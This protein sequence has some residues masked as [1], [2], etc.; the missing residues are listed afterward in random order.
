MLRKDVTMLLRKDGSVWKA[1]FIH[2]KLFQL[3]V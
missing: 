2:S 3:R 1:Y